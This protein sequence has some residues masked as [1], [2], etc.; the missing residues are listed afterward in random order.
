MAAADGAAGAAGADGAGGAVDA[1]CRRID[2]FPKVRH[3]IE[4][5]AKLRAERRRRPRRGARRSVRRVDGRSRRYDEAAAAAAAAHDAADDA[6][7]AELELSMSRQ[8]LTLLRQLRYYLMAR[9][10]EGWTVRRVLVV[11][12]SAVVRK[13]LRAALEK[14]AYQVDVAENG[15][16]ALAQM[17]GRFYD[18]VFMDLQ[19]PVSRPALRDARVL[20]IEVVQPPPKPTLGPSLSLLSLEVMDGLTSTRML[21]QWE[22]HIDRAQRQRICALTATDDEGGRTA[23]LPTTADYFEPAARSPLL[24]VGALPGR[25]RRAHRGGGCRRRARRGR[26]RRRG[27]RQPRRRGARM[28]ARPTTWPSPPTRPTPATRAAS[29]AS[30]GPRRRQLDDAIGG[31]AGDAA[32]SRAR[33]R[34]RRPRRAAGRRARRRGKVG[35]VPEPAAPTSAAPTSAARSRQRGAR[36]RARVRRLRLPAGR[37]PRTSLG[38][39]PPISPP[40]CVNLHGCPILFSGSATV[41]AAALQR[42][43]RHRRRARELAVGVRPPCSRRGAA[44]P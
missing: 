29:G 10:D 19:M 22:A 43:R 15:R 5:L 40:V 30:S 35:L 41:L 2:C 27:R 39:A 23:S 25:R 17:Q 20:R 21:R 14:A 24:I 6:D 33:G 13:M 11:D 32:P 16:D 3:A 8:I 42:K 12:D 26:R 34:R 28:S 18:I 1:P 37:S 9:G 36:E 38:R 31:A 44:G 4:M 7:T